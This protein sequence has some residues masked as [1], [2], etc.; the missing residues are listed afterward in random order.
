MGV[1]EKNVPDQRRADA[2][3]GETLSARIARFVVETTWED[4]PQDIRRQA[5]RSIFNVFGTALGGSQDQAVLRLAKTLTPFSSSG[6]SSVIGHDINVDAPTAAF[7]NA[8]AMNVH[9]FDDTHV[10]TIIHP[11]APVAAALFAIAETRA[12]TGPELLHAFVLGT[13]VECRLGNAISPGH[14]DRG[15]HITSTCGVFGAAAAVGKL[16]GLTIEEMVWAFGNAS[17]QAAGLVET[18]GSMAKSISV[19]N[20]ARNGILSAI[21]AKNGVEG[22][23]EPLEGKRGFLQVT[24][25]APR[26]SALGIGL[27]TDWELSR[28]TFKLYPC[29]VVLTPVIDAC[30]MLRRDIVVDRIAS[31]TVA[32]NPLLKARADR[33]HVTRGREAQVSTQHAVAVS[34]LRGSAGIAD[35]DDKAVADQQV[36]ALRQKVLG[37]D[38][39]PAFGVESAMVSITDTDGR[40]H[41]M[42]CE[43]ARGSI[44]NPLSDAD[45]ADKFR[46]LAAYGCPSLDS[47]ILMEMLWQLETASNAGDIMVAARLPHA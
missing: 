29:G 30:L 15:W 13:E 19:G 34:L 44:G 32:G 40:R 42:V 37:V 27:G 46:A 18:L 35:F 31:I 39:D 3:A 38:I 23:A 22:P 20:A 33:P 47:S 16:L 8:V 12:V 28:N 5:V 24:C 9:D 45:L 2:S 11:S 1:S 14:Y 7:L 6:A 10:N 4:V 36:L 26:M 41:D 21:M 17:A 25:D 43:K